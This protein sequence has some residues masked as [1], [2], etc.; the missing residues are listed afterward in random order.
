MSAA[1]IWCP[2]EDAESAHAVAAQLVEEEWVACANILPQMTSVF[3]WQG[4]VSSAQEAGA[5]FKTRSGL[6]S[7]AIERLAELH[8]YDTPAI[9]G[10]QADAAPPATLVWLA[11]C[12]PEQR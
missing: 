7:G 4:N 10:W 2:F 3:R 8:P 9:A 1:L 5:L 11:D 12:L 6:L